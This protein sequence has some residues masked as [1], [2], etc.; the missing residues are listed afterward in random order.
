MK[1]SLQNTKKTIYN[2]ETI[3]SSDVLSPIDTYSLVYNIPP[4]YGKE[5]KENLIYPSINGFENF[6]VPIGYNIIEVVEDIIGKK[7]FSVSQILKMKSAFFPPGIVEISLNGKKIISAGLN[8][9]C[10]Y[11]KD[12]GRAKKDNNDP[13]DLN[14]GQNI[15]LTDFIFY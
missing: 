1:P 15:Q 6:N 14:C 8:V 2:D 12:T 3:Y 11:I 5:E 9:T 13:D 4:L 7:M 10:N